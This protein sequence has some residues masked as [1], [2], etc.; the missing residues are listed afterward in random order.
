MAMKTKSPDPDRPIKLLEMILIFQFHDKYLDELEEYGL[1]TTQQL[2]EREIME[3]IYKDFLNLDFDQ[4]IRT[5]A[6]LPDSLDVRIASKTTEQE[7]LF[8]ELREKYLHKNVSATL[9]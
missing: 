5:C 7:K 8:K 6:N 1:D 3:E 4:L 9:H 2:K